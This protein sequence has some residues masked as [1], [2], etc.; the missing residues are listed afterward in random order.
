VIRPAPLRYRH[1]AV[2]RLASLTSL[3]SGHGRH[4]RRPGPLVQR[5]PLASIIIEE[6]PRAP[7][8]LLNSCLYALLFDPGGSIAPRHDGALDAAFRSKNDVGSAVSFLSRLNYT[9]C[10]PPVYASQP[11]S[12]PVHATLGPGWRLSFTG[13]GL[14][15]AS[16]HRRFRYVSSFYIP[17]SFSRLNL[18]HFPRKLQTHGRCRMMDGP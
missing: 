12:L 10:K 7:R 2:P 9:A 14:S 4:D 11:G 13:A 3:R 5:C 17:S 8:F 6:I 18:A 16:S 15:P 1:R